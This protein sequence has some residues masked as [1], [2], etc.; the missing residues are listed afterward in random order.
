MSERTRADLGLGPRSRTET[1]HDFPRDED[2]CVRLTVVEEQRP[3]TRSDC[4]DVPRP[5]PW[6]GCRHNLYL[7][8]KPGGSIQYNFPDLDPDE[9]VPEFSCALDVADLGGLTLEELGNKMNLTRERIRQIEMQ[10]VARLRFVMPKE[11]D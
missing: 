4:A 3:R 2:S 1:V 7:D 5:C 10:A 9:M 11:D 8:A 6:V